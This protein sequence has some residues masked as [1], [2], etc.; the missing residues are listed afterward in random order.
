[1]SS[2]I[3]S[4]LDQCTILSPSNGLTGTSHNILSKPLPAFSYNHCKKKNSCK[5]G[6]NPVTL[7]IIS[8][9]CYQKKLMELGWNSLDNAILY[10]HAIYNKTLQLTSYEYKLFFHTKHMNSYISSYS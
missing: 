1:M 6:I 2:A 8:P 9:V 5:K 3:C 4:S 10:Y 7:T